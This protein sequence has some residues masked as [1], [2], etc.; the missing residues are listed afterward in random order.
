MHKPNDANEFLTDFVNEFIYLAQ[1]GITVFN[2]TYTITINAILCDA[3]AKSFVTYTKGHT[4][5]FACLKCIQEG[6]FV[7][8]RVTYPEIHS[9][10]RTNDTFKHRTQIGHHTGDSILEKLNIGMISQIPLDYMHLVCLGVMKRMLQLW[11]KG[12]KNIRLP[13][14]DINSVSRNLIAIKSLY[15]I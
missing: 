13:N 2:R 8:N 11:V 3:P 9:M 12:N 1:S 10:L 5:Y 4:R 7:Q 6:D 14:E 15:S